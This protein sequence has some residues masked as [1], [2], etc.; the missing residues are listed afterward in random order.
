MARPSSPHNDAL[1]GFATSP[2]PGVIRLERA[3]PASAEELWSY[4]TDGS[5]RRDWW[6]AGKMDLRKDGLVELTWFF[7]EL[8]PFEDIPPA[9][10]THGGG[11]R[12][13]GRITRI[14]PPHRLS[15]SWGQDS[16]VLFEIEPRGDGTLLTLTH[17]RLEDR[18]E[19]IRVASG[20]FTH[21]LL[22]EDAIL[23]RERRPFWHHFALA[24]REHEKLLGEPPLTIKIAR[25]FR[26][27]PSAVFDAWF[28]SEGPRLWV[29]AQDSGEITS[30]EHDPRIGGAFR[31]TEHRDGQE[32]V[33]AGAYSEISRGRRIAYS[34]GVPAFSS[35]LDRVTVEMA[36]EETGTI[37]VVVHEMRPIWADYSDRA[38]LGWV[39]IL[40]Q[41]ANQLDGKGA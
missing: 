18:P 23:S 6:A 8:S 36:V 25:R 7:D 30:V 38:E 41:I 35:E 9:Y 26:A 33:H 12:Q 4:L 16:E 13:S 2:R 3:Y 31:V 15:F 27:K 40:T 11:H 20:W 32:I 22:L 14:E 34:F 19:M 21:L 24:Q 37:L 28:S 10:A 17:R 1:S 5:K 39:R 29:F